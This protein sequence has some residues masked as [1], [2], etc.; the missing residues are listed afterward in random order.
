MGYDPEE[1]IA[2]YDVRHIT[3]G[4]N[5]VEQALKKYTDVVFRTLG[6]EDKPFWNA[7]FARSLYDQAGA[8]AINTG[9]QADKTVIE[10]LVKN[11]TEQ[12]LIT[13]TKDANVATFHDVNK[14]GK[15]A[16]TMKQ[17]LGNTQAGKIISEVLAP[18]TG[19]PTSIAGNIVNYSPIGLLKG[20][21]K[22]GVVVAKNVPDLQRQAA[23]EIG[24]GVI[25]SGLFG[26]GAYLA[27]KGLLTGQPKDTKEAQQWQ[28]EGKPA[29]SVLLGGKWRNINSVGPQNLIMLAGAKA[30]EELKKGTD[31]S[32]GTYGAGIGKDFLSQTFL[33]GIQQPLSALT[34]PN[35]YGQSYLGNQASSIVPNIVKDTSKAF[36]PMVRENNSIQDYLTNAL[37]GFR[38]LNTP[39]RDVLGNIIPQE[40]SGVNA[41]VDLF[42]S[43]SPINNTLVQELGRLNEVGQNAT[44]SKLNKS[45][46]INGIK[47]QLTPKQLDILESNV[48]PQVVNALNGL[49][50]STQ[51]QTLSDEDKKNAIDTLVSQVRKQVRGTIDLPSSPSS[52]TPTVLGSSSSNTSSSPLR[53]VSSQGKQI[54]VNP[55][56]GAVNQY[57][58]SKPK[59]A[60]AYYK[61]QFL[62]SGQ[63]QAQLNGKYYFLTD[64]GNAQ[65]VDPSFQPTEPSLTG[66]SELDKLAI[67]KFKGEIA[68]KKNDIYTLYKNGVISDKE[69]EQQLQTLLNQVNGFGKP[70][71]VRIASIKT[72][73]AK[74]MKLATSKPPSLKVPK[75]S[76]FKLKGYK[77]PKLSLKSTKKASTV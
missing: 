48:G 71:R 68:Q 74:I 60:D 8:Q 6:G 58:L 56:T 14:L 20:I 44:P 72:V 62:F 1:S 19:V 33:Q 17:T 43:K 15:V 67:S 73:K 75:T 77:K 64:T 50:Q 5:P 52:Q 29:N 18:F 13:A 55:D 76:T 63:N 16:D 59:E 61:Q 31:A 9:Q 40:P 10:N 12:M 22:A 25:G 54:L 11:P 27:S 49:I 28:L 65:V 45:Q 38:N 30:A 57:D 7:A 66:N 3:W 26:I 53:S 24:R 70:K 34:D 2:K 39:R 47:Q 46:T 41:F 69:A 51:Y 21:A 37:P 4:N 32:I 35:R 23:Q 36:D 42:N